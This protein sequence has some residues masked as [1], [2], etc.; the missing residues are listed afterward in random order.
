MGFGKEDMLNRSTVAILA[1]AGAVFGVSAAGCEHFT[2]SRSD[3]V[4]AENPC[5]DTQFTVYFSENSNR[6]TRPAGQVIQEAG[7]ALK[8][9]NI[10][11]A[12]VVGLSDATGGSQANLT[13]S[14]QRAV[15]VAGALR[16]QGLPAPSF[17][18]DAN[19]EAGATT[20]EGNDDPVRRRAEV[21]L[22]VSPR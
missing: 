20:A 9:C 18:I 4:V 12:R 3:L 2:R 11:R 16:Q 5:V 19:G 13:L 14:Q 21:F 15:A 6:L 10:T 1:L 22:T 17:E 8:D 7:R